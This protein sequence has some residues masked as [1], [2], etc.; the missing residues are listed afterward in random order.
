LIGPA[1]IEDMMGDHEVALE[2]DSRTT[3]QFVPARPSLVDAFG[4]N[5]P[6]ASP[7]GALKLLGLALPSF[8]P[9]TAAR[10]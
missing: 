2:Q 6:G 10:E 4:N 7:W 5:W 9:P 3:G 8:Q 1:D